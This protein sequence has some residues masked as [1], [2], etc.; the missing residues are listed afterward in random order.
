MGG[1]R[2]ANLIF[3]VMMFSIYYYLSVNHFMSCKFVIDLWV[4]LSFWYFPLIV[5][6]CLE[7]NFNNSIWIS[8]F[9][10]LDMLYKLA[11]KVKLNISIYRNGSWIV[12]WLWILLTQTLFPFS[13]RWVLIIHLLIIYTLISLYLLL[14]IFDMINYEY[15]QSLDIIY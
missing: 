9:C 2:I 13:V 3:N 1:I 15:Q 12:I 7:N 6:T 8:L 10:Q 14:E 5:Y 11:F 4:W